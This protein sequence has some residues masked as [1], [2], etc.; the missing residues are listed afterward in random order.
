MTFAMILSISVIAIYIVVCLIAGALCGTRH[1]KKDAVYYSVSNCDSYE[2]F[3]NYVQSYPENAGKIICIN[4][5]TDEDLDR[6]LKEKAGQLGF[7][8]I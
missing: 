6:Q 7:K 3:I 1:C 8:I 2:R 5:L 4:N